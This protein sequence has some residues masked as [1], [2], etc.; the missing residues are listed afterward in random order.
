MRRAAGFVL[1][2]TAGRALDDYR[3][4][5]VLRSAVERKFEILGEALN[6]LHK[7]DPALASQIP[8]TDKSS[9][10]ATY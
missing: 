4:D 6:R 8:Q 3:A 7:T 10:S 1:T 9:L 5:E 2:A